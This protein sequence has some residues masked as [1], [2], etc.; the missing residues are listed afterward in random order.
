MGKITIS[1][2][3]NMWKKILPVLKV[4]YV[5]LLFG[6][7]VHLFAVPAITSYLDDGNL[8]QNFHERAEA[9]IKAPTISICAMNPSTTQGWKM[10]TFF[11]PKNISNAAC[12]DTVEEDFASCI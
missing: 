3:L 4:S 10:N 7:F 8:I 12:G 1:R 9:P 6:G 5:C 2:W 11:N